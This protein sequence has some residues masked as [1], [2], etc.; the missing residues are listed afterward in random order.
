MSYP[1]F[2]LVPAQAWELQKPS[3]PSPPL[4]ATGLADT[5]VHLHMEFTGFAIVHT[6]LLCG[7]WHEAPSLATVSTLDVG[8]LSFGA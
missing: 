1:S 6:L 4:F 7:G 3:A 5:Y 8:I 2:K